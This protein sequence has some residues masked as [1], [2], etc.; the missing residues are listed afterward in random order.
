MYYGKCGMPLRSHSDGRRRLAASKARASDRDSRETASGD[1]SA[2]Q[3]PG[4]SAS[5]LVARAR[6]VTE[7]VSHGSVAP[8]RPGMTVGLADPIWRVVAVVIVA[9][10]VPVGAVIRRP[11]GCECFSGAPAHPGS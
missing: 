4:R 8:I 11:V 6:P 2:Q 5:D 3:E 1:G 7:R 10:L 9:P